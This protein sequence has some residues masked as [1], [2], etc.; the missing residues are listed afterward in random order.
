MVPDALARPVII[1][2]MGIEAQ[3]PPQLQRENHRPLAMN[4][5]GCGL[6]NRDAN[7]LQAQIETVPIVLGLK[8]GC[9]FFCPFLHTF[10]LKCLSE[11]PDFTFHQ[12]WP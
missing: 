8:W 1:L 6:S 10:Y 7:V 4:R 12:D 2:W 9:I 3:G 11:N 5:R